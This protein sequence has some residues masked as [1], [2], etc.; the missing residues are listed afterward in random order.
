MKNNEHSIFK[1]RKVLRRSIL[2][3]VLRIAICRDHVYVSHVYV[4][5]VPA[6]RCFAQV[7]NSVITN[8]CSRI[9]RQ[10][11]ATYVA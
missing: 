2:I 1:Y 4:T 9:D 7:E 6:G 11:Y 10:S 3:I 5:Q 8:E